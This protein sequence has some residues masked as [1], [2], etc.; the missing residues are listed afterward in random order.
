M[1]RKW[2]NLV[3]MVLEWRVWWAFCRQRCGLLSSLSLSL[4][5]YL[6]VC[7]SVS[8]SLSPVS[9][10]ALWAA[11]EPSLLRLPCQFQEK[12]LSWRLKLICKLG[13]DR[14]GAARAFLWHWHWRSIMLSCWLHRSSDTN[15]MHLAG[16]FATCLVS[17]TAGSRSHLNP[18]RW[19]AGVCFEPPTLNVRFIDDWLT[20]EQKIYRF[21]SRPFSLLVVHSVLGELI[22][23]RLKCVIDHSG[24]SLSFPLIS[25]LKPN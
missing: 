9:T 3:S 13:S 24:V 17:A 5:L 6:F 23:F 18:D 22:L 4:S 14:F 19:C 11:R 1:G 7:L 2:P 16:F 20:G 21:A 12:L 25:K 15:L 8:L 10:P